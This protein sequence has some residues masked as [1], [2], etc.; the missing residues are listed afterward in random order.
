MIIKEFDRKG[1]AR[2]IQRVMKERKLKRKDLADALCLST[3]SADHYIYQGVCFIGELVRVAE[4]LGVSLDW[5]CGRTEW[6]W[7]YVYGAKLVEAELG[8]DSDNQGDVHG[9]DVQV[10]E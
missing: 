5:L 2:R 4:F 3:A 9:R 1:C 10:A 7:Q 8:G 6:R